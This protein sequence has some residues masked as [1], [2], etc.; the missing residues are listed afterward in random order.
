MPVINALTDEHHP[1]Q[2]LA[3]LLTLREHFGSLAGLTLAYVGDGNNVAHS[4]HGGGRA[5]G[6]A[7]RRGVPAGL[8]PP[9]PAIEARARALAALHGGRI[10]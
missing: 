4:L 5:D 9:D 6:H 2:A 7:R 8:L 1:C 10:R 3:D